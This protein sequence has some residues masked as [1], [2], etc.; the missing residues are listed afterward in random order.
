VE[1]IQ[2]M[3]RTL[4]LTCRTCGK[5]FPSALQMDPETFTDIRVDRNLERCPHCGYAHR[6]EKANYFFV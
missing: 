2:L 6:Y 4:S 5:E 1:R 3:D